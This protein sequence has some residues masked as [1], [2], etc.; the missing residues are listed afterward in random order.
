MSEPTL[1]KSPAFALGVVFTLIALVALGAIIYLRSSATTPSA[2]QQANVENTAPTV[3]SIVPSDTTGTGDIS[4]PS[5]GLTL[6]EA[7]T[8]TLYVRGAISDPNGCS[9]ILDA[10]VIVY[11]SSVAGAD[12]CTAN[13]NDCYVV[14][15]VVGT[16]PGL[17]GCTGAGD[18]DATFEV[19]FPVANYADPTDAG[20]P[21]A[22]DTWQVKA[23]VTDVAS[24]SGS[25][26]NSFEVQSLAAFS[27]S[28]SVINYG[29]VA[30]GATSAEQTLTF[31]NTGNRNVDSLYKSNGDLTSDLT[32]FAAIPTANAHLSLTQGFAWAAG[33]GITTTDQTLATHVVQQTSGTVPSVASYF[34][35]KMPTA[36]VRGTYTNTLT[37]T[38]QAY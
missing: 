16:T 18:N 21:Y 13:S 36:G 5:A 35:L 11:R 30:L 14:P 20:S 34:L 22:A 6:N 32:G 26:S 7:T 33:T 23:V 29:T 8:K 24:L 3:D 19:T 31:T 2:Q 38:A 10:K 4:L 9:D 37:F 17:V 12:A 25:L 15:S 27:I 1:K 28:P